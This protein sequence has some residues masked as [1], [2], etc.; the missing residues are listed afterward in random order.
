MDG[1]IPQNSFKKRKHY[2][3][4]VYNADCFITEDPPSIAHFLRHFRKPGFNLPTIDH[5]AEDDRDN[6]LRFAGAFAQLASE[7]NRMV[8]T[9]HTKL[10][11]GEA[12]AQ[13]ADLKKAQDS[14]AA[15]E[16]ELQS[17][18]LEKEESAGAV[19]LAKELSARNRVLEDTLTQAGISRDDYKVKLE[20]ATTTLC[21]LHNSHDATKSQLTELDAKYKAYIG[22]RELEVKIAVSSGRKD[23]AD[24]FKAA[25]EQVKSHLVGRDAVHEHLVKASETKANF[26]LLEEIIK[27]EITDFPA[28]LSVVSLDKDN[29]LKK[30]KEAEARIPELELFQLELL[31]PDSF[32]L[33][34]FGT[35]TS[36]NTSAQEDDVQEI[37][38]GP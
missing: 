8:E 19:K 3:E 17:L 5:L 10:Q 37:S 2:W 14:I 38:D 35:N 11:V 32:T 22:H 21:E 13:S 15:M 9:F 24:K 16:S 33:D 7:F 23:L 29:A 25:L 18:R 4:Y 34:E 36:V 30:L 26:E 27:G 12:G 28:E 20:G 6:Y 1:V 31:L